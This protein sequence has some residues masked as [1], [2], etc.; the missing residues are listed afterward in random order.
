MRSIISRLVEVF[1]TPIKVGDTVYPSE[2]FQNLYYLF[3]KGPV[4]V[5]KIEP[6]PRE[7]GGY[8]VQV[9]NKQKSKIHVRALKKK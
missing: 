9:A 5:T 3:P 4:K 1:R 2:Q 7:T 6:G 8:Y